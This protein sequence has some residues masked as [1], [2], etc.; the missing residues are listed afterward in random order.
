ML[1]NSITHIVFDLY[2][3]LVEIKA[4]K[5]F[6]LKIYNRSKTKFGLSLKEYMQLIMTQELSSIETQLGE[7]FSQLYTELEH[8]LSEELEST[9]LFTETE[10]VLACLKKDYTIC[11]LSNLAEPYAQPVKTLNLLSYFDY[12]FFSFKEGMVK[13]DPNLYLNATERI[14]ALP[15]NI[16]MVGDSYKSDFKGA[17]SVGWQAVQI[18]RKTNLNHPFQINNLAQVL[19]ELNHA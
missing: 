8:L 17:Q 7:E 16:L 6:F 14:G 2:N 3:T 12:T 19:K 13:P 11:L 15:T 5:Q 10:E 18:N 1:L 9:T 4:P